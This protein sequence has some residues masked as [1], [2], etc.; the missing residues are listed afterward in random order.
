GIMTE[1][2]PGVY[3]LA[4]TQQYRI[5]TSVPLSETK[6]WQI[7]DLKIMVDGQDETARAAQKGNSF[8][9]FNFE[10]KDVT[11][12]SLAVFDP[13]RTFSVP[14]TRTLSFRIVRANGTPVANFSVVV[15]IPEQGAS[16]TITT[17][18]NGWVELDRS[19]EVRLSIQKGDLVRVEGPQT[20]YWPEDPNTLFWWE[21]TT[22]R[23]EMEFRPT[24]KRLAVEPGQTAQFG[25][26]VINR[27]NNI[28]NYQVS[29]A[30]VPTEWVEVEYGGS[31]GL[32][33]WFGQ[34]VYVNVT[35]PR[36]PDTK[37]AS[38]HITATAVSSCQTKTAA[39]D[40]KV[41][42]FHQPTVD[43]YG[44]AL[45]PRPIVAPGVWPAAHRAGQNGTLDVIIWSDAPLPL[46]ATADLE[47]LGGKVIRELP[48]ID[49]FSVQIPGGKLSDLATLPWVNHVD[50]NQTVR[51]DLNRSV[52]ALGAADL[53][54]M[55]YDGAGVVV[56]L[57]DSGVDY[58]HDALKGHVI[59]GPDIVNRDDDPMD[60][61]GHGT[62]VAGVVVSQHEVLH[63]V[64]PGAMVMAV[65]VLSAEGSG[66][67]D[68]VI[69]GVDWAVRHGADVI[70]LSL[71][72]APSG[73]YDPLSV[74]L[75][76]A[77][78]SGV[79]V[80][81][82]AGNDGPDFGTVTS[83]GDARLPIT[84][85]A[86]DVYR[87]LM[88]Y[89]ARGPTLDGR[90]KPDLVAPGDNITSLYLNH[91]FR[92]WSGTSFAAPHIAGLG[93]MLI[94]AT[95]AEPL[96]IKEGLMATS[97][98]L[99]YGPNSSGA[100][101][102]NPEAALE[103]IQEANLVV[104][105]EAYPGQTVTYE[106]NLTNNGSV[107]DRFRLTQWF[108]DNGLRYRAQ[109]SLPTSSL[110]SNVAPDKIASGA[111]VKA[112]VQ[113]TVPW[114]WAGAEDAVYVLHMQATS[115]ADR[116]A[117]DMD[118]ATLKVKATKQSIAAYAEAAT[119]QLKNETRAMSL[120][121]GTKTTL[122][123]LEEEL[124]ATAQSATAALAA[125]NESRGN[126]YLRQARSMVDSLLETL[127][128]Y[129]SAKLITVANAD[130]LGQKLGN[131][132]ADLDRAAG[133]PMR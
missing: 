99:G 17:D 31:L 29:V 78:K 130:R 81:V 44:E 38:Y 53:W 127:A 98:D 33:P 110:Q 123:A 80:T 105:Q 45:V 23:C 114:D 85:G 49:G 109:S 61:L 11:N 65:K 88:D 10:R 41:Q 66:T 12:A 91:G 1:E 63:G 55:G 64:A 101:F 58:T 30:G 19:D 7:K 18:A 97:T 86:T 14:T 35:P 82:S 121:S 3:H 131:I 112:Q 117:T 102:P 16:Q 108:D 119:R 113:V 89:S 6:G 2:S 124:A 52:P 15:E 36:S 40:L 73:G 67:L 32:F 60:D 22:P 21:E 118:L 77:M 71:G 59:L 56:A 70:N 47:K 68:G 28:D 5:T 79:L 39:A 74:A 94:Q 4:Q 132:A 126:D 62:F 57:V 54:N 48:I 26:E 84:V 37:L 96:L 8:S 116:Y 25:F 24:V 75:D 20:I 51:A 133:T 115:R 69:Q 27:G 83:P 92:A 100:G 13:A 9:G 93:A 90:T 34:V 50:E 122:L 42:E 104:Q 72:A 103:Y 120:N 129:R 76:N 107:D 43:F 46:S 125:G 95:G 87:A 128:E 106:F 111:G